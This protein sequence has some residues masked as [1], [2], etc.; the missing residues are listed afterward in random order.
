ML[1]QSGIRHCDIKPDNVLVTVDNVPVLADFE[2]SKTERKDSYSTTTAT[3]SMGTAGYIA[4]EVGSTGH[5]MASDM[6]SF[7]VLCV[8]VL[9]SA[10]DS[11]SLAQQIASLPVPLQALFHRMTAADPTQRPSAAELLLVPFFNSKQS[12]PCCICF[13]EFPRRNGIE[14]KSALHAVQLDRK[15]TQDVKHQNRA[16]SK[17][18]VHF[19]CR[20]CFTQHVA[21]QAAQDLRLL[22]KRNGRIFCPACS[23]SG[24]PFSDAEVALHA[25][26][27]IDSYVA[28]HHAL[29]EATLTTELEKKN[30][31]AYRAEL[32]RLLKM[33]EQQ[34]RVEAAY[35]DI[36]NLLTDAC[37]RCQAAFVD[38][39]NCSALTCHRC[40]CGFCAWC[41][42][43]CG[44]DAHRH[45]ANCTSNT[46]P[47]R[48]V[49]ASE[50]D[51]KA[52]VM[53]RHR[54]S[55]LEYA[56]ALS[57][58]IQRAVAER[59]RAQLTNANLTDV[60]AILQQAE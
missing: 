34:R 5:S 32:E 33:D 51:W 40:G 46:T 13:E 55:V 18:Q 29:M 26:G 28:S 54:V 21:T 42:A 39:N 1:H 50:E 11:L 12:R 8:E 27:A 41:L 47:G 14:C 15:Q 57:P 37:P 17:N 48:Q 3:Q 56:R 36:N 9:A 58:E 23:N 25:S 19:T 10:R 16:D 45:V 52:S 6:F 44:V 22:G 38:F 4:P 59:V 43:D 2:T 7:G 49:Y 60:L 20:E 53:R 35:Q 24:A 31:K 30:K